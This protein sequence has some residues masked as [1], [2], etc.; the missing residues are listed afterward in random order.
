MQEFSSVDHRFMAAALRLAERG[1]AT[2]RPNPAVGCVIVA[3]DG[4]VV[5]E[6][7]HERAGEPHA[8]I[9][10][11]NAAGERAR[12]ATAYVTLEPCAHH[13]R[14]PPCADRLVAAGIGTVVYAVRD[15]NPEVAGQGIERLR[16]AGIDVR[17]ELLANAAIELNRGFFKRMQA[18]RPW[19]TCKL[20]VSLDGRTALADGTSQ[21]ITS[22]DARRDVHRWRALSAAILSSADTVLADEASLNAR[23]DGIAAAMQ[24]LRVILDT[25]LRVPADAKLFS[26]AGP[27]LFIHSNGP[28]AAVAALRDAGAEVERVVA[29]DGHVS[30]PATLELLAAREINDVWVEAGPR[31]NGALLSAGLIDEL[32]VYQAANVLGA[33]GRGM[34]DLPDLQSMAKRRE[35]R[36]SE[37]RRVGPDLRLRYL[38]E[39]D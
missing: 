13:G 39:T 36:L 10:A 3:P 33:A 5:G 14:T 20:A 34:F 7:W 9:N 17:G 24:P 1:R 6:G 37:M 38:P 35:F 27:L 16:G 22:P 18:G 31:L 4:Q 28:D 23:P 11:L 8:E 15:P 26:V 32:I 21:W 2:A 19:I 25:Q 12:G 29:N 30:L